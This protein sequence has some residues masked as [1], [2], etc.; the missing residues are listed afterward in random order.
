MVPH[1]SHLSAPPFHSEL[2]QSAANAPCL[3]SRIRGGN[4]TVGKPQGLWEVSGLYYSMIQ[5][6]KGMT[7]GREKHRKVA[8]FRRKMSEVEVF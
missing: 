4:E 5:A 3:V 1:P 2:L 8:I 7:L 6:S